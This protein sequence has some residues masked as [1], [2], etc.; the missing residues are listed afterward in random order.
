[1]NYYVMCYTRKPDPSLYYEER[2]AYS[3]HLALKEGDGDFY[4]LNHNS[5]VLFARATEN[6][7]GSLNPKSLK[8]PVLYRRPDGAFGVQARRIEGDGE[9]EPGKPVILRWSSRDLIVFEETKDGEATEQALRE[10]IACETFAERV[11]EEYTARKASAEQASERACSTIEGCVPGNVIEISE[12]EAVYLKRKL[13]TPESVSV[14]VPQ[15]ICASSPAD[16]RKVRA[17]VHYSDGTS[18][19]RS[20]DWDL[21]GVDFAKAGSYPLRGTVHQEHFPFPIAYNRADPCVARWNGKYYFI[22]TNDADDNHTLYIREADTLAG[23]ADAEEI[24]L[25]DS[26]TYEG[27]G[28]LLWAP[29]FHEI[30]GRLY[31]FHA[32]T[33]GEFYCEESYVMELREGGSPACRGDWSAPKRVK[34][35]DGS[36]LCEMGKTITLDMT[37]FLWEGDYYVVWSQRQFLPKDLGAWLYIAKLNPKEP[38]KLLTDPVVLTK[39]EYGWENNHVFVDEGPYALIRG[40][41]LYLTYSGALVDYTYVVSYLVAE[42]GQNL[43][44]AASW[45]KNGYPILSLRS[46]PG[47]Y[48]TG[49][50]AY[51]EDE[52]GIIWNTYHARPGADGVRSSG[53]RRVHFDTDGCPML[54]VTEE[55]DLREGLEKVETTLVID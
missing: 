10:G 30:E 23:L 37:C 8:D 17:A 7:D 54:D 26:H 31:I 33:P 9:E 51:V 12:E 43:L 47:E 2:L 44:D 5:G 41:R 28:G 27:I 21:S 45:R 24:L 32:A 53:F 1:M 6:E 15:K 40:D 42:K 50:N 35:K 25:L 52:D 3:V 19:Q 4:A 11:L 46:V 48:G 22:A 49:H 39:P 34:K 29:E 13:L 20:V 16:L 18:L 36:D 38:W 14:S 55:L